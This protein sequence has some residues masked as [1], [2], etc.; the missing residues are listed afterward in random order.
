MS[1]PTG[2]ALMM[3]TAPSIGEIL[4]WKD[5]EIKAL[6][7]QVAELTDYADRK[8]DEKH[9]ALAQLAACE[10]EARRLFKA[11]E[12]LIEEKHK[13]KESEREIWQQLAA[14][15]KDAKRYQWLRNQNASESEH[16]FLVLSHDLE[17]EYCESAWI[18]VDLDYAID[19]AMKND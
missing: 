14:C 2:N 11:G 6:R 4:A 18:G 13:A 1:N 5:A 3:N 9:E 17:C 12:V 19:E 7:Q 16:A 8:A 15:E 10:K